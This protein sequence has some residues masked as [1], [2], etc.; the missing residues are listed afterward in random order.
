MIKKVFDCVKTLLGTAS[1]MMYVITLDLSW[2]TRFSSYRGEIIVTYTKYQRV[3]SAMFYPLL[4]A[5]IIVTALFF[6][7]MYL[8]MIR[9]QKSY[10]RL[11]EN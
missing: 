2:Q 10:K 6:Y 5:G 9:R 3:L 11:R 7:S 8:D 4:I 1:A